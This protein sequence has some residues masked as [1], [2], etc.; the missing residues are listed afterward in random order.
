MVFRNNSKREVSMKKVLLWVGVLPS[1]VAI[2]LVVDL[3]GGLP[4]DL[5][6]FLGSVMGTES[7]V[8]WLVSPFRL[9]LVAG[10]YGAAVF[11]AWK[12]APGAR[13][14]S[15]IGTGALFLLMRFGMTVSAFGG[16]DFTTDSPATFLVGT[17]AAVAGVLAVIVW[18]LR[19]GREELDES[20]Q[21]AP[22]A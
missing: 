12:I 10:S 8:G 21:E 3:V 20:R 18:I 13:I 6:Q 2:W 14:G 17:I 5:V 1:A 22:R 9:L 7:L 16:S 4:L 11:T 19:E 15:A